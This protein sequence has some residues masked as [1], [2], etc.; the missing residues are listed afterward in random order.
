[1][2]RTSRN[3]FRLFLVV[4][5]RPFGDDQQT[6]SGLFRALYTAGCTS[7]Y[8]VTVA[9]DVARGKIP[10]RSQLLFH[11]STNR[12]VRKRV[13]NIAR[14]LRPCNSTQYTRISRTVNRRHDR[15]SVGHVYTSRKAAGH[16]W[17]PSFKKK[18]S[19]S[20]SRL[21]VQKARECFRLIETTLVTHG[22]RSVP[23]A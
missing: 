1:M 18:E 21:P 10:T 3:G 22:C 23:L 9:D 8:L 19:I 16:Q 20:I 2:H 12:S 11:Y 13:A 4:R 14:H 17:N 6:L 7:I 5:R 15:R